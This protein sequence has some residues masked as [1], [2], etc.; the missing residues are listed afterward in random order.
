MAGAGASYVAPLYIYPDNN[1][2]GLFDL[3]TPTNVPGSRHSNLSPAFIKDFST[4]LKM[5]FIPDGKGD[6]QQTFG[7]EDIF[8]YMYAVFH[9]PTYRERYAEFLKIDFPRL[10]LTSNT[11]LFRDL[12]KLGDRL[13]ELHLMEQFGKATTKYPVSGD[14]VVE[15]IDHTQP[16]NAP[17]Q[18]RVWINKTQYIEGVPPEVWGFHIGGYQICQKWLKDRKGRKLSLNDIMH[19]Q[20]M[21][22]ALAETITLM[23]T[24]F[25]P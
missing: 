18:G 20:H 1:H 6:L 10:P 15:K 16:A 5:C 17:E 22:A 19:Y 24:C 11:N 2:K 4:K 3:E 8:N 9:S 23:G 13:V 21:V 12:C 7:P 25:F 14:N